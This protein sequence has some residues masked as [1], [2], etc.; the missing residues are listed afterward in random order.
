MYVQFTSC[1]Y[2]VKKERRKNPITE[3]R[4]KRF[5][6]KPCIKFELF[7]CLE[8]DSVTENNIL[9]SESKAFKTGNALNGRDSKHRK[10][11]DLTSL[12]PDHNDNTDDNKTQMI[13]KESCRTIIK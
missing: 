7:S 5:L 12:S 3:E 13:I 10:T 8:S 1:V 11:I 9:R 4:Y 6:G 2:W